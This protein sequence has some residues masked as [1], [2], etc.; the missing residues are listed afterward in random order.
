MTF[1]GLP[2][3]EYRVTPPVRERINTLLLSSIGGVSANGVPIDYPGSLAKFL[4]SDAEAM[5]EF[6]EARR[7]IDKHPLF[8]QATTT[9]R[10]PSTLHLR[11]KLWDRRPGCQNEQAI[12]VAIDLASFQRSMAS[13][14]H[15]SDHYE[16]DG[17]YRNALE[18]IALI[19]SEQAKSVD[20][21]IIQSRIEINGDCIFSREVAGRFENHYVELQQHLAGMINA[22]TLPPLMD[23]GLGADEAAPKD[24]QIA[25]LRQTFG[26]RRFKEGTLAAKLDLVL[27]GL[28]KSSFQYPIVIP[29]EE[30]QG[31]DD[32]PVRSFE[33]KDERE[34]GKSAESEQKSEP[35]QPPEISQQKKT[36]PR[37]AMDKRSCPKN[38]AMP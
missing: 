35:S 12:E 22:K 13:N 34:K 24:S 3:S 21:A 2:E 29:R 8:A 28:R 20:R 5:K 38:W 7:N 30:L 33:S 36:R 10:T 37:A 27:D 1:V 19:L 4:P 26:F 18:D 16:L 23:R 15:K 11:V 25:V 17:F 14:F 31:C 6:E 9:L 32:Q